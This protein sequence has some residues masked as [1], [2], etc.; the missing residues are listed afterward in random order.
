MSDLVM[1]LTVFVLAIFVGFEIITKIPPTLHTPLMSGANAISGI[2]IVGAVAAATT[3]PPTVAN[4]LGAL[5]VVTATIN[6]EEVEFLCKPQQS[7]LEVLRD[8]LDL[9]GAKE[10]CNNGNC[11]ACTVMLNGL[12]VNS[13]LVLALEAEGADIQTVEAIAAGC[14][15]L[16]PDRLSYPELLADVP[17]AERR[18]GLVPV[19]VL[20]AV[21]PFGEGDHTVPVYL[22]LAPEERES[23]LGHATVRA[24]FRAS[25]IG[26]IAGCYV[27]DG[28][29][30][31]NARAR[32]LRNGKVLHDR[33]FV[34]SLKRVKDDAK[35]VREG[36]S[37]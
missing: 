27:T 23:H 17:A 9:T 35:E 15:P 21:S 12:P 5:A 4:I 16:L 29:I 25:K 24:V 14:Y 6:G 28:I 18:G 10:G 36:R 7:L 20:W 30:R 32:L 37:G 19:C 26:N 2:T 13:C 33:T 11:G 31:R 1:L 22:R 34:E 8:E 3:A